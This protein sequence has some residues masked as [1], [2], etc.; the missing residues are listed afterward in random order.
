[1]SDEKENAD[2]GNGL[3]YNMVDETEFSLVVR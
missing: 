2:T 1:M 3:E